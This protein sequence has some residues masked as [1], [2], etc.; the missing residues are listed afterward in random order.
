MSGVD[1]GTWSQKFRAVVV[2]WQT[3]QAQTLVA[4]NGRASSSL[5]FGT[6]FLPYSEG[7]STPCIGGNIGTIDVALMATRL[8]KSGNREDIIILG[9]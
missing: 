7:A 4:F 3:R 9:R 1:Q 8:R 2:E 5:A 6:K